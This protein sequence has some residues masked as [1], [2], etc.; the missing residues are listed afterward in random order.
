MVDFGTSFGAD[1]GIAFGVGALDFR[2]I[3][4]LLA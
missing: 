3:G 1:F 2:E 4:A